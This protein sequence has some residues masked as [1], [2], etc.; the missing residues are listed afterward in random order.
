MRIAEDRT[1]VPGI[2]PL[3]VDLLSFEIARGAKFY[4]PKADGTEIPK[5]LPP[6]VARHMLSD[7]NPPVPAL[8]TLVHSPTYT[9]DRRLIL[10]PGYDEQSGI[11]YAPGE[12]SLLEDLELGQITPE[13]VEKA[14]RV[15]M[16]YALADFPFV[17]PMHKAHALATAILPFVRNM[18]DGPTP[19][20]VCTK[21]RPGE[22][23][24]LLMTVLMYPALG[25]SVARVHP[26][27]DESEWRRTLTSV[28]RSDPRTLLIDNARKLDSGALAGA[29]TSSFISDRIVGTSLT[30]CI[31]INCVWM[32]TGI[33]IKMSEEITRRSVLIVLDSETPHP[34]LRGG[35]KIPELEKWVRANR[36]KLVAAL[37][38]IIQS[39]IDAGCPPSH[40]KLGG[41]ESYAATISGILE[42]AG[43]EG[44]LSV[45]SEFSYASLGLPASTEEFCR[46]VYVQRGGGGGPFAAREYVELARKI[47]FLPLD[48]DAAALGRL[49]KRIAGR[50]L[51]GFSIEPSG[52]RE[53]SSLWQI[54]HESDQ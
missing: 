32:A 49:F 16:D 47:G 21:R 27:A 3:G 51:D 4:A 44:F 22:G 9:A 6:E 36:I 37:L 19:I 8:K 13:R 38:I 54:A 24:S 14:V 15:W 25:H 40:K 7:P 31:P 12:G 5:F 52:R 41:F 11:L 45:P 29:I 10:E 46:G 53:N 33:D 26:P 35:F 28:L 30:A 18:I 48:G 43:I 39:W 23:A 42:H 34:S 50:K 2:E 20:H 17:S 1:G